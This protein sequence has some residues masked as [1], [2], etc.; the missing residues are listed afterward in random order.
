M[1]LQSGHLTFTYQFERKK[2]NNVIKNLVRLQ[3]AFISQ[4]MLDILGTARGYNV[5]EQILLIGAS[6]GGI[7]FYTSFS[8]LDRAARYSS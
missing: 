7:T 4:E 5:E 1:P 2:Y 8:A 6:I 3:I